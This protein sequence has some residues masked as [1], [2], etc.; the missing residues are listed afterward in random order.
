L[1]SCDGEGLLGVLY[2]SLPDILYSH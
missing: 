2:E 1:F